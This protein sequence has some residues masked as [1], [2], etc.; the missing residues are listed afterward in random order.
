MYLIWMLSSQWPRT[1]NSVVSIA[2]SSSNSNNVVESAR[3]YLTEVQMDK[4]NFPAPKQDT[5]FYVSL[6][7]LIQVSCSVV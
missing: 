2:I 4:Q 5:R 1:V 3:Q 7:N 6:T